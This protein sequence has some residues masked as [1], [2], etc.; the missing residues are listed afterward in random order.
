[1]FALEYALAKLW[2]SWGITP[3]VVIGHSVGEYVAACVAGVFSL[4]DGLKLIASRARLMQTLPQ[5]GEMVTVFAPQARLQDA[6]KPYSQDI[7]IAAINEPESVVISG[8]RQVVHRV[9]TMLEAEGVKTTRLKVSHAFHSPLVEPIMADFKQVAQNITYSSPKISIIS[10]ITGQF[11]TN[12]IAIPE[13][14]CRHMR[15]PVKFTTSIATAHSAGYEVFVEVGAQPILSMMGQHCLPENEKLWLPSLRKGFSDWQ[16]MLQS[17]GKLYVRGVWVNWSAFDQDYSRSRV[18]LPTYPWQRQRYWIE[19]T[20]SH[21]IKIPQSKILN[22]P[23]EVKGMQ[24]GQVSRENFQE[25]TQESW[26]NWLYDIEWFPKIRSYGEQL[27]PDYLPTLSDISVSLRTDLRLLMDQ[28][29][30][31]VY[32]NGIIQLEVLSVAYILSAFTQMGWEFQLGH[33]FKTSDLT[34]Q[35]GIIHQHQ[36]L[37]G[38]LLEILTEVGFLRQIGDEQWQ[39]IRV[40]EIQNLQEQMAVLLVDYPAIATNLALLERCGSKLAQVLN[41]ECNPLELLFPEGDV[42]TVAKFYQNSPV[43]QVMNTLLQKAIRLALEHLPKRRVVRILEIGGGTGGTTSYILPYLDPDRTEYVFTDLRTLF[44]TQAQQRFRDYSF[45]DYQVLDIEK[46]PLSQGLGSHQYDLVVAANVLHATL[47]LHQT[48]E[49]VQHLLAPGG[50]LL[51]LEDNAPMRWA[52][53]VF[54]LTN[55]WWRFADSDLRPNYPLLS[56]RRWLELLLELGFQD[57]VTI[58]FEQDK[59]NEFVPQHQKHADDS[60]APMHCCNHS[61]IMAQAVCTQ[62]QE[63]KSWLI[64]ADNGGMGQQLAAQMQ[65]QG[66]LCT[67]VFPGQ[68]Y[69]QLTE[70]EFRIDPASPDD[71]R[72]LLEAIGTNNPSLNGVVH[73][74]SLDSLSTESLIVA[75]IEKASMIGCGSTLYLVQ[76]LMRSFSKP[77]CLWLVTQGS[78]PVITEYTSLAVAQSTLW[79]LGKTIAR[80]HPE[81]QCVLVDLDPL[82]QEENVQALFEEIWWKDRKGEERIA[83]RQGQRYVERLRRSS[84]MASQPL[85]L[86]SN[87]T[88]LI[89]G[90]LRGIGLLVAQWMVERGAQHLVLVGRSSADEANREALKDLEQ[91]GVQVVIA[92][93]DVAD[94]EQVANVLTQIQ[95]SMPPLRGIIHAAGVSE[96]R[97]LQDHKWDLFTKVFAPKV[98]GSWNLHNLTQDLPLDFFV[99]FS[100]ASTILGPA[101][102][103]NYVAANAFL[104]ALAHYR[105][106][107]GLPGL[108]IN[109]GIWSKTGMAKI[110]GSRRQVQWE[111]QAMEQMRPLVAL[112]ALEQ[113]LQ[114]N[115][116]QIG[117]FSINWSKLLSQFPLN[118]YPAWLSE[119]AKQVDQP[120]K[121]EQLAFLQLAQQKDGNPAVRRDLVIAYVQDLV[122]KTLGL[123]VSKLNVKEHL[124]D[125]GLDSLIAI[126]LRN[127][128]MIELGVN[129][130]MVKFI[131]SETS[132]ESLATEVLAQLSVAAQL[133]TLSKKAID[134]I[135]TPVTATDG[136]P[137]E[138][139]PLQAEG[140]KLPFFCLPPIAGVVFPYYELA[141]LIGNDQPF[142]GLQS[143]GITGEQKPLNKVEKMAAYYIEAIRKV[144][145]YGPYHLGGW[146]LGTLIAFEMARQLKQVGQDVALLV[147]LDGPPTSANKTTNF[148]FTFNFFLTHSL[149]YIWPYVYD[150][151]YLLSVDDNQQQTKSKWLSLFKLRSIAKVVAQS[152][153]MMKV[154]Q[155]ALLR[156]LHVLQANSQAFINYTPQVYPGKITLLRTSQPLGPS[157]QDPTLGWS[158]LTT[159]TVDL[160]LIS[161]HHLNL[162]RPPYVQIV[163]E[164]LK[165][166][167]SKNLSI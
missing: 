95:H 166:L 167:L 30:L 79:G 94:S 161:G 119:L 160:H 103:A 83:F 151:L 22:R 112:E 7:S 1:M 53:L 20:N 62:V 25:T 87:S 96:D 29:D 116:A 143:V 128:I 60:S 148:L 134:N 59:G 154:R 121:V 85:H 52:D 65:R 70:Q 42:S 165:A 123:S 144:Q 55:D 162:L 157:S 88:Y 92:Q 50:M 11:V 36:R 23:V 24:I 21:L 135:P 40:P 153:R 152:T 16:Q 4:E 91:A 158:A 84:P 15:Q 124:N 5:N 64:F 108:S 72:L 8:T 78:Q 117:V 56:E 9:V 150:Y 63:L 34:E 109:W 37:L 115:I 111:T 163:A 61:I 86:Q 147:L 66:A 155:P 57:A 35:L 164:K 110:V 39:V 104:D 80:E 54:G 156:L 71:F 51:L 113:L 68:E 100:S 48:L 45:V 2:L 141:C 107:R 102:L 142:Y 6:I 32:W 18:V 98:T 43:L 126:E 133:D 131:S 120:E 14:W 12:E 31:E 105:R 140:N 129:I 73:C 89:T 118:A 19:S 3:Q 159:E 75:D 81:L 44:I 58:G 13:Y 76:S 38:R 47:N 97:L 132:V 138:L 46:D 145:P 41:G 49:H 26:Q 82:E 33:C 149:P 127:R 99:L 10:N 17:L 93:A 90:G 74:W 27:P 77:P 125:L 130:P 101:G 67:L 122:E 106:L 139:V 136:L 114:K 28:L 137:P 69:E 146:S